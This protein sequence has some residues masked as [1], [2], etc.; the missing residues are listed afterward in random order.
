MANKPEE[1]PVFTKLDEQVIRE[2]VKKL[3]LYIGD[4]HNTFGISDLEVANECLENM[5][6]RVEKR[7]VYF[8]IFH[9]GMEMG[10]LNEMALYCFWVIKLCP[11][12]HSLIPNDELNAKIAV[13]LFLNTIRIIAT[14]KNINVSIKRSS[15]QNL[16]YSFRYRDLS[17]ESL[18]TMAE[19]L[20]G[21]V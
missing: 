8:H 5:V 7:R 11:F 9:N 13:R 19:T 1:F 15:I 18:M 17:K 10:E 20:I 21:N 14:M 3:A 12:K 16:Y 6:D 2:K 4:I